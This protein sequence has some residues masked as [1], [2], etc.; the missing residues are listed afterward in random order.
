MAWR[1]G[2]AGTDRGMNLLQRIRLW[3]DRSRRDPVLSS[4]DEEAQ[5]ELT[6]REQAGKLLDEGK[7]PRPG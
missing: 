5:L 4:P 7:T 1:D 2:R 3:L 6:S